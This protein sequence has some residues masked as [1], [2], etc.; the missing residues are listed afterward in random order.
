VTYT[1]LV[2]AIAGKIS[3]LW[4]DRMLYRDFCPVDHQRPAGFLYVREAGWT[5]VN[6]G[7]VEW[8]F[9]AE[10]ELFAETDEYDAESTEALRVDQAAVLALFGGPSLAVGDRHIILT[11]AAETPG[12]GVAYVSFTASWLDRRPGYQDPE[13]QT[14]ESGGAPLMEDFALHVSNRK[15]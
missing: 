10:L 5:D 6:I 9:D 2:E 15:D 3:A 8:S 1:D 11:A 14:P 13:A 4:P 12:P 7:L